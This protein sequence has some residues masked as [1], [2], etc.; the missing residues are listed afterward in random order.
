V[1]EHTE[2]YTISDTFDSQRAR[3]F[4]TDLESGPVRVPRTSH[5]TTRTVCHPMSD[6]WTT[7]VDSMAHRLRKVTPTSSHLWGSCWATAST[8]LRARCAGAPAACPARRVPRP[9]VVLCPLRRVLPPTSPAPLG[10][11]PPM[12]P[13]TSAVSPLAAFP[14]SIRWGVSPG[15]AATPRID[16]TS[17]HGMPYTEFGVFLS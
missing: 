15:Y 2:G 11:H 8:S 5:H 7:A 13:A 16:Y 12:P 10:G 14:S 6:A 4:V 1:T 3:P 9:A 17:N